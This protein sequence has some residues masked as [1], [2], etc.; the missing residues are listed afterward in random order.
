LNYVFFDKGISSMPARYVR[1]DAS[2]VDKFD[3]KNILPLQLDVYH[4]V[5]NI[6]GS[7]LK[8]YPDAK[9]Q[10]NGYNDNTDIEKNNKELSKTRVQGI[11]EY[12]EKIWSIQP[13][14]IICTSGNL[15]LKPSGSKNIKGQEE[16]RR[17]EINSEDSRILE[18]VELESNAKMSDPEIVNTKVKI[19]KCAPICE[20]HFSVSQNNKILFSED[21]KG[22][23]QKYFTW[24]VPQ[25]LVGKKTDTL[26][27]IISI[28]VKD[29]NG[30]ESNILS[31]SLPA[32]FKIIK[33]AK[34]EIKENKTIEKLSLV[35]FD[36]NSSVL[37]KRNQNILK[38]VE[39]SITDHSVLKMNG[40]TDSIGTESANLK[41]SQQRAA[42]SLK[43]L[44]TLLK[45]ATD[46]LYSEGFGEMSPLYDNGLPEG[47]F[48][49][50][51]CQLIIETVK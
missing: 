16:N 11:K 41:L 48:Y 5:L 9:I 23:P 42:N 17:V 45:P 51:T 13:E 33:N 25:T 30:K 29:Q 35:L 21:Q 15:P 1:L 8:K 3:E 12:L 20:W 36:F 27:F 19:R 47:R 39:G 40:Y 22:E 32:S 14:R 10:L 2:D 43:Q 46:K 37:S 34:S 24:N 18:S 28:K 4:N 6:I 26:N 31:Q 49:N 44:K 38:K 7:R 50:R